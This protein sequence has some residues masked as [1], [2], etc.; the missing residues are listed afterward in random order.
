MPQERLEIRWG[1]AMDFEEF[2]YGNIWDLI[3]HNHLGFSIRF[4]TE[5][6]HDFI[7]NHV[8]FCMESCGVLYGKMW[9]LYG[10]MWGFI[11]KHVGLYMGMESCG[12][13]TESCGIYMETY[14]IEMDPGNHMRFIWSHMVDL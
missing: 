7:W 13:Y 3:W 9:G 10:N 8:E 14:G 12:I 6:C 4:H 2:F 5:S 1:F 11:W